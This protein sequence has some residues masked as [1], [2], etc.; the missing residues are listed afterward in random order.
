[1]KTIEE[2]QNS[3]L[4]DIPK[5]NWSIA[6]IDIQRELFRVWSADQDEFTERVKQIHEKAVKKYKKVIYRLYKFQIKNGNLADGTFEIYIKNYQAKIVE[7]EITP[8]IQ[9][10][11]DAHG[12]QL[13]EEK[14]KRQKIN[15]VKWE[16]EE[17]A[18]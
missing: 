16:K 11:I 3:I 8:A 4:A 2:A 10:L 7:H 1:M 12:G 17:V 14:K 9:L 18:K 6:G 5:E 15:P 13:V